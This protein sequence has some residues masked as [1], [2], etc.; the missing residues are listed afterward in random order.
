MFGRGVNMVEQ[1]RYGDFRPCYFRCIIIMKSKG[2]LKIISLK[3]QHNK[4]SLGIWG[5]V[6]VVSQKSRCSFF[7]VSHRFLCRK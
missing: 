3:H 6:F 7:I 2:S 5:D 1:E 4:N